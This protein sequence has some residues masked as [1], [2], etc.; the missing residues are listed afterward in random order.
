MFTDIFFGIL[1]TTNIYFLSGPRV[2]LTSA[3]YSGQSYISYIIGPIPVVL[4]I[5][6]FS[7]INA[8]LEKRTDS[9]PARF[10]DHLIV[11][12]AKPPARLAGIVGSLPY[13]LL[14]FLLFS[15]AWSNVGPLVAKISI[16]T[17]T[18]IGHSLSFVLWRCCKPDENTESSHSNQEQGNASKENNQALVQDDAEDLMPVI[19][20]QENTEDSMKLNAS[21]EN[22]ET[23]M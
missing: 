21:Q 22:I 6:L 14:S 12:I 2:L 4:S 1:L 18:W 7:C 19:A 17:F 16:V 20:L 8:W 15:D 11:A 9:D 13:M 3:L 5:F 23:V 10:R